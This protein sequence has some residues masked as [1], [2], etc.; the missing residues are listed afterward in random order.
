MGGRR[1]AS[2]IF[3]NSPPREHH[4]PSTGWRRACL[5]ALSRSCAHEYSFSNL[6][7]NDTPVDFVPKP[8]RCRRLCKAHGCGRVW[9]V[10][11]VSGA[12]L[13]LKQTPGF[14]KRFCCLEMR[15]E[16]REARKPKAK[17][18]QACREASAPCAPTSTT[19]S[20]SERRPPLADAVCRD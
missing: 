5:C 15:R 2:G 9:T 16:A 20:F 7:I 8:Q 1:R 12:S 10:Q 4:L 13:R 17:S 3:L 19:S 14:E 11:S 18:R 6:R